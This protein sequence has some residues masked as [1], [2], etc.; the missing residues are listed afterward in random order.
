MEEALVRIDNSLLGRGRVK[1]EPFDEALV[2]SVKPV[3]GVASGMLCI[4]GGIGRMGPVV[5]LTGCKLL[6]WSRGNDSI[7][8]RESTGGGSVISISGDIRALPPLLLNFRGGVFIALVLSWSERA[9][10]GISIRLYSLAKPDRGFDDIPYRMRGGSESG[11]V[12]APVR[13]VVP[14]EPRLKGA[15]RSSTNCRPEGSK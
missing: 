6:T 3:I 15:K 2:G 8:A 14:P 7:L 10:I 9:E 1:F 12:G 4:R 5:V 13:D 11:S